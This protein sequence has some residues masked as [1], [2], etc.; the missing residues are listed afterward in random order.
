MKLTA[1]QFNWISFIIIY[2]L[3]IGLFFI[4]VW[5]GVGYYLGL[6]VMNIETAII[7]KS[8]KWLKE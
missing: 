4:K 7:N 6:I 8:D 5:L 1:K 3:P 2:A